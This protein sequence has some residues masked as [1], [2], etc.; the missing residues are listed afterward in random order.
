[1]PQPDPIRTDQ[2][3]LSYSHNDPD[4]AANLRAQ[5][6]KCGL[7]VFRD[8]EKIRQG[9]LWLERLQSELDACTGF[10]VLVGRDGVRRWVGAETQAALNRHFVIHDDDKRLPIFP[11]VLGDTQPETLPVFLRLFQATRWNGTDALPDELLKQ[12][13]DRTLVANKTF[14]FEGCP[15]V[16]LDAYRVDQAELFF[17]RQ[18][19]TLKA[20]ACFDTRAGHDIVRWLEINGNSGSG[21][22][23]LMNAGLLPLVDQG[24]LWPRTGYAHW[25]RIGIRTSGEHPVVMPMTPGQ[26]PVRMLAE[27]LA[28]TFTA[29]MTDI[30]T[31]LEQGEENALAEWLRSRKKADTAFLLAIDQFEELFTFADAAER[32]RFDRLLAAAL[33]DAE[34]PLFVISTVRADFLDRFESHLPRLNQLR[35]GPGRSWP[36]P[37]LSETGLREVIS[38]PARLAGLDVSAVQEAMVAEARDEP[39]AL[40]LVENA[41]YWLWEQRQD[42]RLSGQQFVDQGGLAGILSRGADDLLESLGKRR[43]QALELLFR[44]VKVD[45]EGPRHTRRRMALTEAIAVAGG[46]EAGH[47]LINRL[48]GASAHGGAKPHGPLRLITV[49]EEAA[50]QNKG[51]WV[52]LIHETLIH[53]KGTSSEGKP[54]PYWPTLWNYID[55][56]KQN[57]ARYEHLQIL[58]REWKERTGLS[59]L[60]GLAGWSNII[61]FHGLAVPASVEA[62]YL[63]WSIARAVIVVITVAGIVGLLGESWYWAAK[64]H[65]PLEAVPTRWAYKLG[66]SVPLPELVRIPAGHFQMGELGD[67]Y[68]EPVHSVIFAQ[69]FYMGAAEVT[70]NQFDAFCKATGRTRPDDRGW[71]RSERPVINVDWNDAHSYAN[72]LRAMTGKACRLP[73]EAEWEYAAR[74]GTT[75]RYPWGNEP[76]SGKANFLDSGTP[77]SNKQTAPVRSFGRNAWGLYDTA[78]NVW[79]WVQD[80]WHKSYSGAPNDERAWSE[81][82]TGN[83]KSRVVRGGAY[84]DVGDDAR[85]A[86][87]DTNFPGDRKYDLGFRVLCES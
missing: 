62:R 59:R 82:N 56:H 81:T 67:R 11:I 55:E 85:S 70:F 69:P 16:G 57:A 46:G 41:L 38:G 24:W 22:S 26:Y 53:S 10:I 23:S 19:D 51:W 36:L 77:W 49:I 80:C 17:G 35:R 15:F 5:L 30:R 27:Q 18:Q 78:G 12:I 37:L 60:F 2:V 29:E 79:E 4:A 63:N 31:R 65:L 86:A 64:Y 72:W 75:T 83:C 47:D 20:L 54:H 33:A 32:T 7:G 43:D 13:R 8:A 48:A 40:P 61:A 50:T 45:P 74:A 71:G 9:E 39:G 58:A 87:R 42:N 14:M 3:F 1:M 28:V 73:S 66:F 6:E 21:K 84:D 68:A 76:G 34:C 52:N 25:R 44:L